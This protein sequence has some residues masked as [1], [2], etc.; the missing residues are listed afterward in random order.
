MSEIEPQPAVPQ[1][2]LR[3]YRLTPDRLVVGL[4]AVEGLLLLSEWFR[5]FPFNQHKG[6]TVLIAVASVGVA[7][8]AMFVWLAASLLFRWRF[9]FTIRAL[10]VLVVVVAIPCSW[11]AV[12]MKKAREQREAA[13]AIWEAGIVWYDYQ[14]DASR[15][16]VPTPEPT[17]AAWLRNLLGDN[18]FTTV[19]FAA[20]EVTDA[21]L[22][23][24]KA[25]T[26]LQE[27]FLDGPQLTDTGLEHLKGMTQL[28]ELKL[29][30]TEVSDSGLEH[31]KALKQLR[32][33]DVCGS[34]VTDEGVKRLQEAL[35]NC[36]IKR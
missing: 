27:L 19:V 16:F 28:R 1:P 8:L 7:L 34:R 14:F 25:L 22:E 17:G 23:H 6:W 32:E 4:L 10:L 11:L 33:L 24:L 5:W 9:Q 15:N 29:R 26:Q 2:K 18:F 30:D 20:C 12:E 13:Q 31:L 21:R 35:P 36:K 3:W